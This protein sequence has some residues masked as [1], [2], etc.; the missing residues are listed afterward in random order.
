MF[1]RKVH[2]ANYLANV[3]DHPANACVNTDQRLRIT[4]FDH[5][6]DIREYN[7]MWAHAFRKSSNS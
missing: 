5:C 6:I 3:T 4:R 1:L 2:R 7:N